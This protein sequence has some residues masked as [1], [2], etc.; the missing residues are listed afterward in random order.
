M[1]IWLQNVHL[2]AEETPEELYEK[3]LSE[4]TLVIYSS[5]TRVMDVKD[6]FE[7]QYPGLTVYVQDT[8]SVDLINALKQNIESGDYSC[9][10]MICSDDNGLISQD[11]VPAG[12][13]YKYEPYD[14][15][16]Q[17]RPENDTVTLPLVA[18]IEMAFY[19]SEMYDSAPINNWW[20]LTEEKFYGKVVMPNPIKSFS[21][22]GLIGM[23]IKNSDIMAQAYYDLYG[24]ELELND[25]ENAG[26]AYWRMLKENGLILTNSSDE[27]VELVGTPGLTD[28]PIGIMVSSKLRMRDVGFNIEPIY[29]MAYFSG[30]YTPNSIMIAGGCKNINSAKLF[31]RWILGETDGQGEGYKPYLQNG[32][33]SVRTDVQSETEVSLDDLDVLQ[34]DAEYI[35][36]HLDDITEFWLGLMAVN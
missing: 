10:I 21:A 15:A 35:Y 24:T 12:I 28:T 26:K 19:N 11:L 4:G 2:D 6:S 25:G 34:L 23:V 17:I 7:E 30:T 9:D 1:E 36:N 8:R 27:T 32:A 20:E 14:I 29:D 5:S 22:M 13:V 33:W 18:E 31:I 3:A 16:D